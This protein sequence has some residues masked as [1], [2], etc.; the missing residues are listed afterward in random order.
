MQ[1][2]SFGHEL[3]EPIFICRSLTV[4]TET[5]TLSAGRQIQ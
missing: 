4:T 3:Q 5:R 1:L 2:G